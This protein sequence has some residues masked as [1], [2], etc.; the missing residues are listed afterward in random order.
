MLG[1]INCEFCPLWFRCIG[2]VTWKDSFE[3]MSTELD[4][5]RRKQLA[6]DSL[7]DT[8]R[9]SQFT[10][11]CLNKEL[12]QEVDDIES[13]RKA[14]SEKIT[15]KLNE[16]EEQR[17]ALEMFLANN[18]L[19]YVAGEIDGEAYARQSNVL[20]LGLETTKQ[21]V[22]LIKEVI[23]RLVPK[24][25]EPVPDVPASADAGVEVSETTVEP[26]KT[27]SEGQAVMTAEMPIEATA[28]TS[29]VKVE[30][31]QTPAQTVTEPTQSGSA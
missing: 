21:E 6:L 27:T 2:L 10:Y 25:N 12:A 13:R 7:Y 11:E 5:N 17:I 22:A 8:G 3:R 28:T 24:E 4:V 23:V 15:R 14:L 29:E 9:I 19:A 26:A 16:F 20:D 31:I 1:K 18:E 30:P